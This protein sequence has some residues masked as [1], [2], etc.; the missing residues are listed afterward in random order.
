ME[1]KAVT[2]KSNE[3]TAIPKLLDQLHIK[4]Q[5]ITID[6]MGTQTAIVEKIRNKRA[7]YVLVLYGNHRNLCTEVSEYFAEEEFMKKIKAEGNYKKTEE[8]AHGR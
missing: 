5:L 3:I 1:Q 4:E 8:K 6:A 2:E 7:D